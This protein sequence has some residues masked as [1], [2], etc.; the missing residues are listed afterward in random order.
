MTSDIPVRS[1]AASAASAVD[2]APSDL[3][4][5][6][7]HKSGPEPL[8]NDHNRPQTS[9]LS[10]QYQQQSSSVPPKAVGFFG[11]SSSST[12]E[13]FGT[14]HHQPEQISSTIAP[15]IHPQEI[16]AAL[17]PISL[18]SSGLEH[19]SQQLASTAR[20]KS[21]QLLSGHQLLQGS[22]HNTTVLID[23]ETIPVGP[24]SSP[25]ASQQSEERDLFPQPVLMDTRIPILPDPT[26]I[27][28]PAFFCDNPRSDSPSSSSPSLN[29]YTLF[30]PC[31]QA[32]ANTT[33]STSAVAPIGSP[34]GSSSSHTVYNGLSENVLRVS[35][36]NDFDNES[37]CP[38]DEPIDGL[39][40]QLKIPHLSSIDIGLGDE[41]FQID[42]DRNY[43]GDN[44]DNCDIDGLSISADYDDAAV[45]D[46]NHDESDDDDSPSLRKQQTNILLAKQ[47]GFQPGFSASHLRTSFTYPAPNSLHLGEEARRHSSFTTYQNYNAQP[48]QHRRRQNRSRKLNGNSRVCE[49]DDSKVLSDNNMSD[50]QQQ[51]RQV[52]VP[53]LF[54][55]SDV[56]S[57]PTR[58]LFPD[59]PR[60]R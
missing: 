26:P 14:N 39:Q 37:E 32:A 16:T 52:T 23:N 55:S 19:N 24:L 49:I 3:N 12:A 41:S 58:N 51:H 29:N 1:S 17:S 50:E 45:D 22:S 31:S 59:M 6:Y 27:S 33:I 36:G 25:A 18:Q 7:T 40:S 35:L 5:P 10:I 13:L 44:D 53:A 57:P 28:E 34:I 9:N 2:N 8:R 20:N 42:D 30:P 38:I 56:H 60:F 48:R 47:P 43:F 21:I 54:P 4:N 11:N 15:T 46:Y